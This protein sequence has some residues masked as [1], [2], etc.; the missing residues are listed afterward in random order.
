M[1]GKGGVTSLKNFVTMKKEIKGGLLYPELEERFYQSGAQSVAPCN[2]DFAELLPNFKKHRGYSNRTTQMALLAA[3]YA[4][5]DAR[6]IDDDGSFIHFEQINENRVGVSVGS[7]LLGFIDIVE[8]EQKMQ[9]TGRFRQQISPWFIPRILNNTPAG[10]IS[11]EY[12]FRGPNTSHTEAC[13]TGNHSIGDG[14]MQIKFNRADC[15]IVGASD[16]CLDPTVLGGF[17]RI[18]A[19]SKNDTETA[20]RPFDKN[21]D[22]FVMGEGAGIL[23]LEELENAKARNAKIYAEVSGYAATADAHHITAPSDGG[24]AAFQAMKLALEESGLDK[25]DMVNAHATSTPLGD[26]IEVNAV[27]RIFGGENED[28][29]ELP[30]LTSNKGAIGHLLA[31]AG[32]VEAAFSCLSVQN[33]IIPHTLNLVDPSSDYKNIVMQNPVKTQ[34]NAAIS[35]SFGFGGNNSSVVFKKYVE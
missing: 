13:A 4:L 1:A 19:L 30:Y 17:A 5:K 24:H 20:S 2:A 11:M 18:R 34:V 8:T 33:D 26:D 9:K 31:A 15:M 32:A 3:G 16:S 7:C 25:V 29:Q 23:V 21:R 35:N 10:A 27:K 28:I 6:L 22:G 12:N 14:F